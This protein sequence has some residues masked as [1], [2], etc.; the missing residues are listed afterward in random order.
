MASMK[1]LTL[2]IERIIEHGVIRQVPVPYGE[3]DASII[4]SKIIEEL[5]K[6]VAFQALMPGDRVKL[7]R[8]V[9]FATCTCP[10]DRKVIKHEFGRGSRCMACGLPA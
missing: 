4:A 3:F 2:K 10:D 6:E 9:T 8:A 1:E 7:G 5:A